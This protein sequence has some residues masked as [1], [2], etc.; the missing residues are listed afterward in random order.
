L[1]ANITVSTSNFIFSRDLAERS[2]GFDLSLPLTHDWGFVLRCLHLVEPM[3]LPEP[4]L[5]Y[6]VH[7]SNTWRQYSDTRFVQSAAALRRYF[8]CGA[9][10]E[11]PT[12][13][14]RGAW[15]RFFPMFL[16]MAPRGVNHTRLLDMQRELGLMGN[17]PR[18]EGAP[19]DAE[20]RSAI[21]R[22]VAAGQ[23]GT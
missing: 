22:L 2:G 4:L 18:L 9:P 6:R 17:W 19:S 8:V 5:H 20:E 10:P 13:P 7:P 23:A 16:C 12:A 15:P 1:L 14:S 3:Y 21:A 11:N